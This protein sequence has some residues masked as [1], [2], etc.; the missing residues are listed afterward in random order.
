MRERPGRIGIK[1]QRHANGNSGAKIGR[2]DLVGLG[3]NGSSACRRFI[4]PVAPIEVRIV[5]AHLPDPEMEPR[6]KLETCRIRWWSKTR[7][8]RG[9]RPAREDLHRW[10]DRAEESLKRSG[11]L[12][13]PFAR[14]DLPHAL[15]RERI[16][17][18]RRRL[19][20][21]MKMAHIAKKMR[22]CDRVAHPL[23]GERARALR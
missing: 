15:D 9:L 19:I 21:R 13:W 18:G 12:L 5:V 6:D 11:Q 3:T 7:R 10:R 14:L 17:V 16:P 8:R 1:F 22:E 2:K 23:L 20:A 4:G